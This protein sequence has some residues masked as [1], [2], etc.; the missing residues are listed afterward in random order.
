MDTQF[1]KTFEQP[2]P[3][4]PKIE[5]IADRFDHYLN[6]LEEEGQHMEVSNVNTILNA[7]LEIK[8]NKLLLASLPENSP[9]I[10]WIQEGIDK[11][12]NI[13]ETMESSISQQSLD[14]LTLLSEE[15]NKKPE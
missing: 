9:K 2:V 4:N 13:I 10:P 11:A 14:Y 8:E 5:G 15:N 3:K 6:Q 12:R 7:N 1:N